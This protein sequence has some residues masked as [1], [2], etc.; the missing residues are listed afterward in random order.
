MP[1]ASEMKWVFMVVVVDSLYMA[2]AKTNNSRISQPS[3]NATLVVRQPYVGSHKAFATKTFGGGLT[4][5]P[6]CKRFRS[7]FCASA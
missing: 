3:R 4:D 6:K 5:Q 2:K 7:A 1:E